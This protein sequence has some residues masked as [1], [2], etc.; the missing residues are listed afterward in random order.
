MAVFMRTFRNLKLDVGAAAVIDSLLPGMRPMED[1]TKRDTDQMSMRFIVFSTSAF[2]CW[3]RLLEQS[4]APIE[5]A[6]NESFR[7]GCNAS[8]GV[9]DQHRV[10]LHERGSSTPLTPW[11]RRL[12]QGVLR[13][14]ASSGTRGGPSSSYQLHRDQADTTRGGMDE[15]IVHGAEPC[16]THAVVCGDPTDGKSDAFLERVRV[17]Y[18]TNVARIAPRVGADGHWKQTVD[19]S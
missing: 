7:V 13:E 4:A 2:A 15:H 9:L 3:Q 11:P 17:R 14:S 10:E 6:I 8:M 1:C 12:Q 5:W 19:V 16:L 18:G